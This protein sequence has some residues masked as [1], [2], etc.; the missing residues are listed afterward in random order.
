MGRSAK[1]GDEAQDRA[2]RFSTTLLRRELEFSSAAKQVVLDPGRHDLRHAQ[3]Q[4]ALANLA[5]LVAPADPVPTR[6][7]VARY[8]A[9]HVEV[10]LKPNTVARV[11]LAC[12]RI[13]ASI[14]GIPIHE[15]C[16]L[17]A[18]A[19]YKKHPRPTAS[20]TVNTL[21]RVLN[22]AKKWGLRG[23]HDIE[24][25]LSRPWSKP[26]TTV[27][28]GDDVLRLLRG[29]DEID[30]RE[31]PKNRL[32]S[33]TAVLR[34]LLGTGLRI[35]EACRLTWDRVASDC[36]TI[37]LDDSKTGA[38]HVVMGKY[39]R[40]LLAARKQS[41]CSRFVF[42]GRDGLSAVGRRTVLGVLKEAA[43]LAGLDGCVVHTLRHS[44]AT[45]ALQLGVHNRLVQE[46]LGWSS[47]RELK[48]Y[49]HVQADDLRDACDRVSV[50]VKGG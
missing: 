46:A 5:S 33:A 23:E 12:R 28:V 35:S 29:L 27:I 17:H 21:C 9:E 36:A 16:R 3:V 39:P 48:R 31:F 45:R 38:R 1:E 2:A 32:E 4:L 37:Y 34:F 20:L 41:K 15:V 47:E 50:I 10:D 42:P 14:G 19:F 30:E 8:I 25:A 24:R 13:S 18:L 44:W 43:R 11:L 6:D 40:A 49:A 22:L 7:V 26:R